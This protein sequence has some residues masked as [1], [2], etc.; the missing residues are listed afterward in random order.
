VAKK[1]DG[2][3]QQANPGHE[4]RGDSDEDSS[5]QVVLLVI[6]CGTVA[7]WYHIGMDLIQ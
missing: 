1:N 3:L 6:L 4:T 2:D 7:G 5:Q